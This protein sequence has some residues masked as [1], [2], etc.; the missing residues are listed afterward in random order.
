MTAAISLER[1]LGICHPHVKFTRESWVFIVPVLVVSFGFNF[2][3]FVERK[4]YF[5]NGT[6]IAKMQD[7]RKEEGYKHAHVL[8]AN[9]VCLTILPPPP[10]H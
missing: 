9:V 6:F 7:F 5:V 10:L 8:W 1:Y 2:P 4:L 3:I